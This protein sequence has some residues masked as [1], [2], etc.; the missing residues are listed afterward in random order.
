MSS[1]A[2]V[3]RYCRT[4][5]KKPIY[6]K[7]WFWI[8]IVIL[9]GAGSSSDGSD[10]KDDIQEE[11]EQIT[12]AEQA[13]QN[14]QLPNEEPT[15]KNP[16]V[17]PSPETDTAKPETPNAEVDP[18]AAFREM[19]NQYNY[20]GSAESDK[21]HKPKCRWT[22]EITDQNLVHFDTEEEAA[23]ANYKPCGTCK[24]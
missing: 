2:K 15:V 11:T 6:K 10:T 12:E 14:N 19:L 23:A 1:S 16:A 20:V 13:T 4:K 8:I 21:Y 17:T 9:L 22:K 7:W 24:P 3:C 5:V 18:E